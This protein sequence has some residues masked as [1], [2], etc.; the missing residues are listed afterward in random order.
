MTLFV[1]LLLLL[2]LPPPPTIMLPSVA[3]AAV[4]LLQLA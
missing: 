3:I 4:S 2:L 1:L